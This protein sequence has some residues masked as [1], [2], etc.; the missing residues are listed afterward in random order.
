MKYKNLS[1]IAVALA[2]FLSMG[3]ATTANAQ[4]ATS[5]IKAQFHQLSSQRD[6]IYRKLHVLDRRAAELMKAGKEP[7]EI[8]A[9]QVA[10][11][12]ELDLV[13]LRLE[14]MAVRYDLVLRPVP[15]ASSDPDQK[16]NR[17]VNQAFGRGA[18]RTKTELKSQCMVMLSSMDF[19]AF[20]RH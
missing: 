3:V 9:Q 8:H 18:S 17:A 10:L 7:V 15:T 19:G 13:Q 14:T 12:D 1:I 20:L 6:G 2:S 11:Q 4:E 5:S 16:T